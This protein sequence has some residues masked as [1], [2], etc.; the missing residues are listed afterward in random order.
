MQGEKG[1]G[2]QDFPSPLPC[3]GGKNQLRVGGLGPQGGN[4]RSHLAELSVLSR[5]GEGAGPVTG[6]CAE[7]TAC[8]EEPDSLISP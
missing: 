7:G 2:G 4:V 3:W 1:L 6:R 5:C 8:G